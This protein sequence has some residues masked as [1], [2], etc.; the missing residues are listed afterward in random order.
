MVLS[1]AKKTTRIGI[2]AASAPKTKVR[3]LKKEA[4][5]YLK[6]CISYFSS[7]ISTRCRIVTT[8]TIPSS[9]TAIAEARPSLLYLKATSTV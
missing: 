3:Y 1:D 7:L 8:I 6:V 5:L 4:A 9:T 2:S